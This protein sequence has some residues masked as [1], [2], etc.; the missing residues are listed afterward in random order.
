MIT[1]TEP[2]CQAKP[3]SNSTD[4]LKLQHAQSWQ[5]A[6]ASVVRT[7]QQLFELLKLN[8]EQLPESMAAACEQFVLR[9]PH[10]FVQRMKQGDWH[11]PLLRQV[12]PRAQELDILPGYSL[13]PLHE[14]QSNPCPGLIH[15]YRGRVL[16]IVSRGCAIHCRYCFRRHFPYQANNP[17]RQQWQQALRYIRNDSTIKE[18]IFS[19]GDPLAADDTLLSALSEAIADIP[20]VTTLRVHSRLPVVIPERITEQC[21]DWLTGTRLR[22]VMVIHSNHANELDITVSSSLQK[23]KSAGITVLNQTVLLAGVNDK[24]EALIELSERLFD[25]GVLPYYLHMLDKVQGAAH[26][27]VTTQR[28]KELVNNMLANLPGYLVPKL[29]EEQP[30]AASKTPVFRN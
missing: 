7:P 14:T 18:V 6:L 16:L 20:H 12:L 11:D 21:I 5:Q 19:G 22:P 9:V 8:P 29:V 25:S 10:S 24:P 28:A 15:K 1:R 2:A 26:F 4:S 13:D 23:L 30:G 27:Q 17:S 3:S